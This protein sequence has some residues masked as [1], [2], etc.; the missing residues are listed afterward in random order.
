MT[1]KRSR[2]TSWWPVMRSNDP[3]RPG[4]LRPYLL[5]SFRRT[6]VLVLLATAVPRDVAAD[7]AG[8]K[9]TAGESETVSSEQ[10]GSQSGSTTADHALAPQYNTELVRGRAVWLSE[11]LENEFGISTVPEVAENTLALLTP[12]GELIPIVEN[13][14]GRALRKDKR[15]REMDLAIL[16]RRY[17][18]HPFIQILTL[19]EVDGEERFEVDYWCD[20][21]AIVMYE[22]GPCSCCQDDNRLRKR[23]VP[24]DQWPPEVD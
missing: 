2:S 22:T 6:L 17:Q 5:S 23:P 21:C 18:R 20:V 9:Q 1:P 7:E 15:L 4:G 11:G 19:Y 24:A 16:A 14:R 8:E 12:T 3:T 10:S 13:L